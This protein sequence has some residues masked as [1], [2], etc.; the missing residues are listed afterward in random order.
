M[1]ILDS[2]LK[3][4]GIFSKFWFLF[5]FDAEINIFYQKLFF[6]TLFHFLIPPSTY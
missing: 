4:F 5:N 6:E 2:N 1:S 3:T